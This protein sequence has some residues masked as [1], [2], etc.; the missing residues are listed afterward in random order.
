MS[1]KDVVV[2][3]TDEPTPANPTGLQEPGISLQWICPPTSRLNQP[4]TCTII[5]KSLSA[6]RL[7][8]VD[9]RWRVPGGVV[10]KGSEP[11]AVTEGDLLVWHLGNLE[12]RQERRL[13]LHLVPTVRGPLLCSA[14]VT[15]TGSATARM[16]I[17]EPKLNLA[18]SAP[19]LAVVG[20]PTTVVL[21]VSN[22]GD[23]PAEHVRIH[24]TLGDGLE[25]ASGKAIEFDLDTLGPNEGR[26]V[27][28]HCTA[29]AEG[30]QV[31]SASVT[32]D[33]G[34]QAQDSAAITVQSPRLNLTVTGPGMRFLD[35]HAVYT[36]KVTNP[37]TAPARQVS[38]TDEVPA[39]FKVVSISGEGRHDFASRTVSWFLG[40]LE[41]GQS[42]EV[43][44]DLL[45]VNPGEYKLKAA[46]TAA[47]GLHAEGEVL[48]RLEG[49]PGLQ[50]EL[51]DIEDP[52]EVGKDD[53][54]EIRV[55]NTGTR[56]ETNL[57]VTCTLP[58]QMSY[59][60][61]KAPAGCTVHV[62]GQNV[63]FS[64]LPRLAPRADV[65]YRVSVHCLRPGDLRFQARVRADGLEQPVLR[66]ESTR[67][68]GDERES[69]GQP[70]GN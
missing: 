59:V 64:P 60:A 56:T 47:R 42:K 26:T 66:E 30:P 31:C 27:L 51:A 67:V 70:T 69:L 5:V 37:G 22:P 17:R 50:M 63:V 35:R 54:Y 29:K 33:G 19:K 20:D 28:L 2:E 53:S 34:L 55:A 43:T 12:P 49:L 21:S 57:Q 3:A 40:G 23:A 10:A 65:I 38:L 41:P 11:K 45:A 36:L 25:H 18:A 52:V 61:A 8:Q 14:F 44:L 1:P 7:H 39:G 9:V 48:T 46:V 62:E 4:V 32:G 6:N 13:D 68:Y 16:E 24:A 15:F 58:P